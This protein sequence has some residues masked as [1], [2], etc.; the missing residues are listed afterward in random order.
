MNFNWNK[1]KRLKN[2]DTAF[3]HHDKLKN[4]IIIVEKLIN[5]CERTI[6]A[7]NRIYKVY[8]D[9]QTSLKMIYIMSSM[10]NQKKLQRIQM[11]INKIRSHGAH[12]KFYWILGHAD[13]ESN[14]MIDKMTEKAHSFVLSS[15]ERLHHE[16]TTRMSL[17]RASSRKIWNKRWKEETKE[18]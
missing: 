2:A 9:N 16:V 1:K 11:T 14:E 15:L 8:F 6:D 13:I 5:Y 3:T 12:L 10:F 4:L 7:R 17:I 18:T